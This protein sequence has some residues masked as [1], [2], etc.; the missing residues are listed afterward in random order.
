MTWPGRRCWAVWRCGIVRITLLLHEDEAQASLAGLCSGIVMVKGHALHDAVLALVA[1]V[2]PEAMQHRQRLGAVEGPIAQA[3][4]PEH[5]R[6][7]I[8]G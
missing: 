7:G 8:G 6:L 5:Q 3:E 2:Q 1:E 4:R